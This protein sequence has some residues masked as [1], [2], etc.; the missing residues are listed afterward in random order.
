MPIFYRLSVSPC[1]NSSHIACGSASQPALDDSMLVS[2]FWQTSFLTFRFPLSGMLECGSQKRVEGVV[3]S[4][5]CK[6]DSSFLHASYIRNCWALQITIPGSSRT[7]CP[8]YQLVMI[9]IRSRRKGAICGAVPG[10]A[11]LGVYKCQDQ[12]IILDLPPS[13]RATPPRFHTPAGEIEPPY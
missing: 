3:P 9:A 4:S 6:N 1:T 5:G 8:C 10:N 12:Q 7:L 2:G 11:A 13:C